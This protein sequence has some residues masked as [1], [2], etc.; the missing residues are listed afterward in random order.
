M[1]INRVKAGVIP[2]MLKI[3]LKFSLF[4]RLLKWA[5]FLWLWFLLLMCVF[6]LG[7]ST[8]FLMVNIG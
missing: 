6:D 2:L 1:F 7:G 4:I 8:S 3:V 5:I